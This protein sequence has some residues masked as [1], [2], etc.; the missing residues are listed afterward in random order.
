MNKF[1]G[2][3]RRTST[4]LHSSQTVAARDKAI[5]DERACGSVIPP[6]P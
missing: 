2:F 4:G 5:I 1:T 6:S 3:R